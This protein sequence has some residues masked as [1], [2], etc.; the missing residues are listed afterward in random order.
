MNDD[1]KVPIDPGRIRILRVDDQQ[2][3]HPHHLLHRHVRVVEERA[4]LVQRELVHELA[5]GQDRVLCHAGHA[6]HRDGHLEAM[7][8]RREDFGQVVLDDE[9]DPVPL[10]HL[11]RRARH[12][13]VE[14]PGLAVRAGPMSEDDQL[15]ANRLGDDGNV[16]TSP[17]MRQG[18]SAGRA[19]R[20]DD[21]ASRLP[22][23]SACSPW[24]ARCLGVR[25]VN[26][27]AQGLARTREP[28][29]GHKTLEKVSSI[30]GHLFSFSSLESG[31]GRRKLAN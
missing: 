1:A 23:T 8:V 17:S 18:V 5:P 25:L 27:L 28:R 10:V 15:G 16:L 19:S 2:A 24:F 4:V 26:V 14:A 13:P 11:D 9:A 31:G 21:P 7:P 12:A 29:R 6:V 30:E 3:E 20:R 22:E